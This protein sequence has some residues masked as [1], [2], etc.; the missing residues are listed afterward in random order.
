MTESLF[1]ALRRLARHAGFS[2]L[3]ILTAA[4]GVGSSTVL[5]CIIHAALLQPLPFADVA[6][7]Q[8]LNGQALERP[9]QP[10]GLSYLNLV[11]L[12]AGMPSA[13]SVAGFSVNDRLMS[14]GADSRDLPVK[15]ALSTS[16]IA[17]AYGVAPILG[18]DFNAEEETQLG[19]DGT[20]L[21]LISESLWRRQF[22]ADPNIVGR[23]IGINATIRRVIGV[24]PAGLFDHNRAPIDVWISTGE[25]GSPLKAGSANASRGYPFLNFAF[26]R[27]RPGATSEQLR[28]QA[29]AVSA[30]LARQ[31]PESN[32]KRGI[33]VQGV[34]ASQQQAQ[35]PMLFLLLAVN[36]LL[37]AIV[38]IN[39]ANLVLAHTAQRGAEFQSRANLGASMGQLFRL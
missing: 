36:A 17:A 7:L 38:S 10:L 39:L 30:Q 35:K 8:V 25:G 21:M 18:R 19:S 15:V 9:E 16:F 33:T 1:S 14:T 5:F 2:A 22:Q 26:A 23:M 6:N 20:A 27:L 12:R 32:S 24:M 29:Q 28:G 13:A 11:D 34:Q 4:L 31:Y 37:F 3:S